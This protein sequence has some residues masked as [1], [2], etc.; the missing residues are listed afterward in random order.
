MSRI[1]IYILKHVIIY[2]LKLSYGE[3]DEELLLSNVGARLPEQ[4]N[5]YLYGT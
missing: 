1:Y 5:T 3:G 4:P 2:K